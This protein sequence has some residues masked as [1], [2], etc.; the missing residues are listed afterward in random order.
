MD[1]LGMRSLIHF[2]RCVTQA[3]APSSQVTER[4]L[5]LLLHHSRKAKIICEIG[6]YEGKT[7]VALARNT[8]AAVYSIDPFTPGRL[9]ICYGKWIA[10]L[11]RNRCSA[12]NLFFIQGYS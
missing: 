3:D 1:A 12:T 5:D 11:H 8:S 2:V 10:R 4:E 9:G 6:C 7:S